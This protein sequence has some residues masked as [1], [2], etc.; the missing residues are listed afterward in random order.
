MTRRIKSREHAE[1][2][3]GLPVVAEIPAAPEGGSGP[4]VEVA[5]R[6]ESA[7]SDAYR[8]LAA[9]ISEVVQRNRSA[10]DAPTRSGTTVLVASARDEPA[11]SFVAVNLAAVYADEGSRVIVATTRGLPALG[12]ESADPPPV[13][14]SGDPTTSQSVIARARPSWIPG[15]SSLA[16]GELF[17]ANEDVLGRFDEF[18]GATSE[19]VD[20]LLLEAPML[21]SPIGPGLLSRVDLVVVVCEYGRTMRDDAYAT[22]GLLS[23]DFWHPLLGVVLANSPA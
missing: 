2:A 21:S 10:G 20:L 19:A 4:E 11:R 12:G 18:A 15:V 16:L 14:G 3:F 5:S 17:A 7:S 1:T 23:Q 13:A 9:T 8:Q 6:P 22:Q